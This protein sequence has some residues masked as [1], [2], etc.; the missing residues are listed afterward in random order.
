M[1]LKS[2]IFLVVVAC[3]LISCK[4]NKK[5]ISEYE[6]ALAMEDYDRAEEILDEID[7]FSL[8]DAE[9]EHLE[10]LS[11]EKMYEELD[12]LEE[13]M[14]DLDYDDYSYDY[15]DYDD[16]GYDDD[17]DDYDYDDYSYDYDDY[18]YYY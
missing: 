14:N 18:D 7:E 10:R 11:Q 5:L 3:M 13:L 8:T 2:F 1:K 16:Y 12:E 9:V 6:Q 17:Y 15:D 4:D